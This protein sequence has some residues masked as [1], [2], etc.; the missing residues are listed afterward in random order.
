MYDNFSASDR[1][2]KIFKTLPLSDSTVRN[3][4]LPLMFSEIGITEIVGPLTRVLPLKTNLGNI[5][6]GFLDHTLISV[7]SSMGPSRSER[8]YESRPANDSVEGLFS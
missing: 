1:L 2:I 4:A 3:G 7:P 5:K 6:S 8:Q